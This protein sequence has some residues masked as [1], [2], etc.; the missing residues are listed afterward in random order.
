[1]A[2]RKFKSIASMVRQGTGRG[3]GMTKI[4]IRRTI[5]KMRK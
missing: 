2:K 5:K 4:A 3:L 1:M